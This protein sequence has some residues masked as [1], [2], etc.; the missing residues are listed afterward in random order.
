MEAFRSFT[1]KELAF[2]ESFKQGELQ[3]QPGASILLEGTNSP[4]LYTVLRGAAFRY[5]TIED[6]RRQILNFALPGDFLGLQGSIFDVMGHGVEALTSM[7]LC[8][9][10]RDKLSTLFE[11]HSGLA[12]DV[13]WLAAREEM[14]LDEHLLSI[15][16]RT[17]LERTAYVIWRLFRRASTV[18][19]TN[20][21]GLGFPLTQQ[22]LADTVG[23]SIVHTNKTIRRLRELGV[24][25]WQDRNVRISDPDRLAEIAKI[26]MPQPT[27]RPFI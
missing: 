18:G 21:A 13:T 14:L 25:S 9:F 16:R 10:P 11:N 24:V 20:G 27:S 23:L 17:A 22:Q 1:D 2:V 19:A 4:H 7:V 8:V 12:Y 6:G 5:K 3:V 15:G 26:S